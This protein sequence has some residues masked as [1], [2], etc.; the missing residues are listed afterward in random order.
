MPGMYVFKFSAPLSEAARSH[1]LK[2]YSLLTMGVISASI[3]CY[4]D[5]HYTHLGGLGT[6]LI[7]AFLF[8]VARSGKMDTETSA[9]MFLGAAVLEG[10]AL[11]PIVHTATIYYPDALVTAFLSTIAIFFSFSVAALVAKRREFF[12][13]SGILATVAS[14]LAL[15]SL[16]NLVLRSSFLM[17]V[18][19][20]GGLVMFLGYILVDTQIMIERFESGF[21]KE[22]FVRPACDLFSDLVG[23]FVRLLIILMRKSSDKRRQSFTTSSSPERKYYRRQAE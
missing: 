2:V 14:Y 6:A 3:G 10:M 16:G 8:G 21:N 12:Y 15:A 17:D 20:Y 5:M 22:N 4:A 7:G 9:A 23:V 1:L 18:Q 11:S 19:L 13:L